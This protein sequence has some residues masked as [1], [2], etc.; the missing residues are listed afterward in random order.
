MWKVNRSVAH[1][2][3]IENIFRDRKF[4]VRNKLRRENKSKES[5]EV[6]LNALTIE[7]LIGLKLELVIKSTGGAR[8]YN[9][10]IWRTLNYIIKDATIKFALSACTSVSSAASFLGINRV[11]LYKLMS[12][13]QPELYFDMYNKRQRK[14]E[15]KCQKF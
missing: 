8:L 11:E 10:P 1:D 6:M 12:K 7:E 9:L 5:F 14:R 4:S 15:A 13:Y 2:K 3:S